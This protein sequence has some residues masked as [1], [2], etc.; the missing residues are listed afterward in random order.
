MSTANTIEVVVWRESETEEADLERAVGVLEETLASQV[1]PTVEVHSEGVVELPD[2]P[3]DSYQGY[4]ESFSEQTSLRTGAINVC[5]YY[6][7]LADAADE[8]LDDGLDAL[9]GLGI[10]A[11]GI[12]SAL[13]DMGIV[14]CSD[15]KSTIE[16]AP[17]LGYDKGWLDPDRSPHAVVNTAPLS[18]DLLDPV[19]DTGTFFDNMVMHEVLHAVLD[20]AEAP[21][22]TTDHSFGTTQGGEISPM[23]TAYAERVTINDPPERECG[24][25]SISR[26]LAHTTSLSECTKREVD[27]YMTEHFGTG[28]D[29]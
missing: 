20:K 16:A 24:S 28:S 2:A 6:Y 13:E 7:S 26:V 8:L 10:D 4:L 27:R 21:V 12:E 15:E 17:Y 19:I 14:S 22:E 25:D 1:S 5:L 9:G 3:Y 11:D 23:L 29:Q 18:F